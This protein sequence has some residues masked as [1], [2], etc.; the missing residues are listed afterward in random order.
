MVD[1]IGT[2]RDARLKV[3]L[4]NNVILVRYEPGQI[5]LY[6]LAGAPRE[7]ANELREKRNNWPVRKWIVALAG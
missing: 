1:Y 5:D 2:K 4:E 3:M 6:L 7:L